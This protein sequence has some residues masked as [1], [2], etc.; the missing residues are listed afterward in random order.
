MMLNKAIFSHPYYYSYYLEFE[1]KYG[2][3]VLDGET[4]K[5]D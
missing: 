2:Y 5:A 1:W 4:T 3:I